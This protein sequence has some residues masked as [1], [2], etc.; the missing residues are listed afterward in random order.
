MPLGIVW[1]L[2]IHFCFLVSAMR[3]EKKKGT[4]KKPYTHAY[5]DN[6]TGHAHKKKYDN[7]YISVLI[8]ITHFSFK[9][10]EWPGDEAISR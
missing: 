2:A 6:S 1:P 4:T 5:I 8:V 7:Y 10:W 9:N 3:L